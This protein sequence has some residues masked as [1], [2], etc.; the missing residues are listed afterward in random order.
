MVPPYSSLETTSAGHIPRFS[1]PSSFPSPLPY[2]DTSLSSLSSSGTSFSSD[3]PNASRSLIITFVTMH[4]FV[5]ISCIVIMLTVIFNSKSIHRQSTWVNL[6]LS[7]I[8]ACFVFAFLLTTG[9]LIT[10]NPNPDVCLFQAA[11]VN[12]VTS[13]WVTCSLASSRVARDKIEAIM[14]R[15]AGTMLALALQVSGT[16]R[17]LK[18]AS[19]CADQAK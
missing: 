7:W 15:T 10:P 2:S 18:H 11:G 5:W 9:Q 17:S 19:A 16:R 14:Y 1:L 13:L 4:T 12:A 8:I 3:V 6:N